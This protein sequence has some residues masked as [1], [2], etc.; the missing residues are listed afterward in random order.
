MLHREVTSGETNVNKSIFHSVLHSC[1][2][3]LILLQSY[4]IGNMREVQAFMIQKLDQAE[5]LVF[6][7][8]DLCGSER[9]T[10]HLKTQ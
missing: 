7:A 5:V 1:A 4:M 10:P 3:A 8:A 2:V 6:Q 9:S